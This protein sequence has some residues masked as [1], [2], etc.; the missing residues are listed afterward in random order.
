MVRRRVKEGS[1][2][3]GKGQARGG[4]GNWEGGEWELWE[5]AGEGGGDIFN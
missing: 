3:K 2:E 4:H 5:E 1:C